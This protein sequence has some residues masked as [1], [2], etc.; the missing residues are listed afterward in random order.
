MLEGVAIFRLDEREKPHLNSFEDVRE[1]ASRL[2]RR[3]K[4]DEAWKKLLAE[5]HKSATIEVN[6][7]PWR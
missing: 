7:A 6:D 4:G 3:D 1:R 2:Y 5:L